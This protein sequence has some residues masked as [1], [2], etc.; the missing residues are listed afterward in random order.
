MSFIIYRGSGKGPAT[1]LCSIAIHLNCT[2]NHSFR[3]RTSSARKWPAVSEQHII[4]NIHLLN[5]NL[6]ITAPS[7][8]CLSTQQIGPS[9]G[10]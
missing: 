5:T 6:L 1:P 8:Q 3:H 4:M 9:T 10:N 7:L 2:G